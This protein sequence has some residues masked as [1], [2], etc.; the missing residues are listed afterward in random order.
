[1][2]KKNKKNL[3][4]TKYVVYLKYLIPLVV[5]LV[6]FGCF[7]YVKS[8]YHMNEINVD[9]YL[10]LVKSERQS[11]VFVTS[12]DCETCDETKALLVKMLQGSDIVTYLVNVDDMN[13][14]EKS[15]FMYALKETEQGVTSP[16]LLIIKEQNLID[17]FFGPF[18]EDLIIQ[19]LKN[20]NLIKTRG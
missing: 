3:D 12:N 14:D 18:D 16:S 11:M 15:T 9:K 20:N 6:I 5:A 4:L 19:F 8:T 13:S 10:K 17:S 7:K 2:K 1:M